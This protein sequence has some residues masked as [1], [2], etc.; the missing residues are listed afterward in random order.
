M[1]I[2]DAWKEC[3]NKN[4]E[5]M[6][7]IM[8]QY[9]MTTIILTIKKGKLINILYHIMHC[10][11]PEHGPVVAWNLPSLQSKRTVPYYPHMLPFRVL[12]CGNFFF[13]VQDNWHDW[14]PMK[15]LHHGS[16]VDKRIFV[17]FCVVS[18]SYQ[19]NKVSNMQ[20]R[21][22]GRGWGDLS[23]HFSSRSICP[24]S[25]SKWWGDRDL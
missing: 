7:L 11:I 24:N 23:P 25:M 15:S 1:Q 9:I 6:N 21:C 18:T 3:M 16:V 2:M 5:W 19:L 17:N 20:G 8:K 22:Q 10:N 4:N 12:L 14:G 13:P